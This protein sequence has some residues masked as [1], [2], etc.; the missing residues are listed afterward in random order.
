MRTRANPT[1]WRIPTTTTIPL[2]SGSV[3][4]AISKTFGGTD[5]LIPSHV[6]IRLSVVRVRLGVLVRFDKSDVSVR[7]QCRCRAHRNQCLTLQGPPPPVWKAKPC[8]VAESAKTLTCRL[9]VRSVGTKAGRGFGY[10]GERPT[11]GAHHRC[12]ALSTFCDTRQKSVSEI[13]FVLVSGGQEKKVTQTQCVRVACSY[14]DIPQQAFRPHGQHEHVR[15]DRVVPYDKLRQVS[16]ENPR[17]PEAIARLKRKI[18]LHGEHA[19]RSTSEARWLNVSLESQYETD[20]SLMSRNFRML[21]RKTWCSKQVQRRIALK[22]KNIGS[23][24]FFEDNSNDA[25][26]PRGVY[27]YAWTDNGRER[28]DV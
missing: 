24:P 3:S 22:N 21:S 5:G 25:E 19:G 2:H 20:R 7:N 10:I 26:C 1:T 17:L 12:A 27:V 16:H 28:L 9:H 23:R 14:L 15:H 4:I 8:G 6:N 11:S 13:N 18:D